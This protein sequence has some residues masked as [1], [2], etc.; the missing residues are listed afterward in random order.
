EKLHQALS[1]AQKGKKGLHSGRALFEQGLKLAE[2]HHEKKIEKAHGKSPHGPHVPQEL[3]RLAR[4]GKAVVD[5]AG[6]IWK[7]GKKSVHD[8]QHGAKDVKKGFG[9]AKDL[10]GHLKEGDFAG[11]FKS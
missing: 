7:D 9:H 8:V 4:D 6:H 3:A 10:W 2:G 5:D 11:A 1:V